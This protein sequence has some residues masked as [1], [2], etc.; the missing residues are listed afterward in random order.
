[1]SIKE[2]LE[3]FLRG[4]ISRQS[5]YLELRLHCYDLH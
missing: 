3:V 1:M 2:L 5:G 4:R